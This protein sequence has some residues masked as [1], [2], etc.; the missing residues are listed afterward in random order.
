ML[1]ASQIEEA[2]E[3]LKAHRKGRAKSD[4]VR[5]NFAPDFNPALNV[6]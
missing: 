5:P 1:C 2:L 6:F 4:E 3:V